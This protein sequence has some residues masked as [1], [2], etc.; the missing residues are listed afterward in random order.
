MKTLLILLFAV[1]VA[2]IEGEY[3][4]EDG[5]I[6]LKTDTF[7]KALQDFPDLLVEFCEYRPYSVASS[8][9]IWSE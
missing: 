4:E 8:G 1:V 7:D 5:V 6:V 2:R 9:D 3:L